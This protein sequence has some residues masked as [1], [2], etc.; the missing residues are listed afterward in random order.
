MATE[1][2]SHGVGLTAWILK[3]K[4]VNWPT[5]ELQQVLQFYH[6]CFNTPAHH[7]TAE[8]SIIFSKTV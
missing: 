1:R 4:C 8:S 6:V 3:A 5:Y 2:H 7:H